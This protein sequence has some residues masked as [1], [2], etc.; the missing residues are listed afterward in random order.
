M[1]RRQPLRGLGAFGATALSL[2][3]LDVMLDRSGLALADGGALPVRV[4]VWFW[5]N[6]L[7]PEHVFPDGADAL[8]PGL[9]QRRGPERPERDAD[10]LPARGVIIA[11]RERGVKTSPG[12][13]ATRSTGAR[14]LRRAPPPT[15]AM[16]WQVVRDM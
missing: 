3:L 15:R 4:G 1:G 8:R 16:W 9:R 7:R 10:L 13:S 6:G 11:R 5:G 14:R 12:V 2:P